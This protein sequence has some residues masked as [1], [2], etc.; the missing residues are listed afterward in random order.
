MKRVIFPDGG[1]GEAFLYEGPSRSSG[2]ID[3]MFE[4]NGLG[5]HFEGADGIKRLLARDLDARQ[6]TWVVL[7]DDNRLL[8]L[9]SQ[10][11]EATLG[12]SLENRPEDRTVVWHWREWRFLIG[13]ADDVVEVRTPL[14]VKL[15]ESSFEAFQVM[16]DGL[17]E[18]T[19]SAL[20]ARE[21]VLQDKGGRN[22]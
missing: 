2:D 19:F 8:N 13:D 11:F 1:H 17:P 10:A 22:V 21:D 15:D 4:R 20:A 5:Y 18:I 16:L 6:Y 14:G 7:M 12:Y 9:T 3:Q